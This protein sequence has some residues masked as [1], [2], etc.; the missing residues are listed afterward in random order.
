MI[1][2]GTVHYRSEVIV[3][4]IML[5]ANRIW[6]YA[7]CG[8]IRVKNFNKLIRGGYCSVRLPYLYSTGN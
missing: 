1:D 5:R 4:G 6:T 7:G 8:M 3:E 2:E